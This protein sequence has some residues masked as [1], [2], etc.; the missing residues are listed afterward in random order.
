ML[1]TTDIFVRDD[2]QIEYNSHETHAAQSEMWISAGTCFRRAK[3]FG[4]A[5]Q[6]PRVR[7]S[8]P[9]ALPCRS[10]VAH[11]R[12][13]LHTNWRSRLARARSRLTPVLVRSRHSHAIS[14]PVFA[15]AA[16]LTAFCI[17]FQA[18]AAPVLS[19]HVSNHVHHTPRLFQALTALYPLPPLTPGGPALALAP[20]GGGG[21]GGGGT[22]SWPGGGGGG[23]ALAL[24]FIPS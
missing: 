7:A 10:L 17:T 1:H 15:C 2:L 8:R 9:P 14:T 16:R 22:S 18:A 23:G 13:R 4:C 3:E 5:P 20:G 19:H 24:P 6:G 11:P 21:G 12:Y